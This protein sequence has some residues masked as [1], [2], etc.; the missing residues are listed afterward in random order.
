LAWGLL[1]QVVSKLQRPLEHVEVCLRKMKEAMNGKFESH[2][3][4]YLLCQV[5]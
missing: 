5:K 2:R 3:L 1:G 4:N